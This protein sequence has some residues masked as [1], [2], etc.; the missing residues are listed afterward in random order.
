MQDINRTRLE[1][2]RPLYNA[3]VNDNV[4]Y[5][6]D[7]TAK[8]EILDVIHKEFDPGYTCQM[9][10]GSCV[11][12]MVVYAFEQMDKQTETVKVKFK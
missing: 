7:G 8:N 6:M 12:K 4:L 10:C 2:Y 5:N 3:W 1:T 9:Y 11:A